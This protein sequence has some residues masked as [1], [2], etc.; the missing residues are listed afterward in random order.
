MLFE[1]DI[2]NYVLLLSTS[3]LFVSEILQKTIFATFVKNPAGVVIVSRLQ[4]SKTMVNLLRVDYL[5]N[6]LSLCRK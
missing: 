6:L 4:T 1:E 3:D 2:R 5:Y